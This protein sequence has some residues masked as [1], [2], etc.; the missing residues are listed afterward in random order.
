MATLVIAIAA[1]WLVLA[2]LFVLALGGAAARPRPGL[3]T[4]APLP[5]FHEEEEIAGS[6]PFVSQPAALR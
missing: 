3:H 4:E 6:A 5:E 1:V 2:L